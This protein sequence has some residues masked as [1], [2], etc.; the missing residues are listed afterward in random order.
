MNKECAHVVLSV[1][2][3]GED[4]LVSEVL[5]HVVLLEHFE[6][7]APALDQL[8]RRLWRVQARRRSDAQQHRA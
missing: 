8:R 4:A 6:E 1:R 2:E 3:L 5:E 7:V